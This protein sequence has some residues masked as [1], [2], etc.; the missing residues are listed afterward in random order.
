MLTGAC[1]EHD[2]V[3]DQGSTCCRKCGLVANDGRELQH[4]AP[5]QFDT[6]TQQ[7]VGQVHST[8]Y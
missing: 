8:N 7:R 6:T 1:R 3:F 4:D 2:F 5:R